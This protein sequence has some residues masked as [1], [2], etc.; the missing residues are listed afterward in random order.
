M[1]SSG[2]SFARARQHFAAHSKKMK[3]L[4]DK[5]QADF[6]QQ[7]DEYENTF[8]RMDDAKLEMKEVVDKTSKKCSFF[9]DPRPRHVISVSSPPSQFTSK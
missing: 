9:L 3:V 7:L 5:F 8:A 4:H 2:S 6:K 1:I